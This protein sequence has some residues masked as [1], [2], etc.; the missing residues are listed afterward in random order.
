M[1][2]SPRPIGEPTPTLDAMVGGL[3][4]IGILVAAVA[5]VFFLSGCSTVTAIAACAISVC[6]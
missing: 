5:G 4:A 1:V 3:I 6:N 2:T